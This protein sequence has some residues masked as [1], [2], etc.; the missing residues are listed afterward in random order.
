M[1]KLVVMLLAGIF[2]AFVV[3]AQAADEKGNQIIIEVGDA[4]TFGTFNYEDAEI[5]VT[6][7]AFNP[8]LSGEFRFAGTPL[9]VG[10]EYAQSKNTFDGTYE[11]SDGTIDVERQEMVAFVRLGHKDDTNI[12]LG[13]RKFKYDFSNADIHQYDGG[14][15]VEEDKNGEATGDLKT[16]LD[17]EITLAI[18]TEVQFSLM[19]GGTYFQKAKYSWA[20]DKYIGGRNTGRQTGSAELDALTVKI[21]PQLSVKISDA[22]RVFVNG[23]MAASA[24]EGTPDGEADY[25][26]V[27]LYS[28]IGLGVQFTFDM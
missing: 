13:Y 16:G 10:G 2:G 12:R 11:D 8:R 14:R 25:P 23:T 28:A 7:E 20:Y 6:K 24:W 18:G 9:S 3:S 19:L 15:L 26:G 1:K 22:L 4:I 27:D 5:E 17:A 21:R